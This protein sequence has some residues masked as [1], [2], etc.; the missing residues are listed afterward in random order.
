VNRK[1][2]IEAYLEMAERHVIEAEVHLAHQRQIVAELE[3]HGRGHSQT[4]KVAREI[5][6]SFEIAQKANIAHRDSLRA[7]LNATEDG[8]Q[9]SANPRPVPV[10]QRPHSDF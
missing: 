4:A 10:L 5:M 3:Q 2:Q 6:R 1:K 9:I 8:N 7:A